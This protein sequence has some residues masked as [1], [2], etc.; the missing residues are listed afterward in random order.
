MDTHAINTTDLVIMAVCLTFSYPNVKCVKTVS[1]TQTVPA[2]VAIAK[3]DKR[4]IRKV[5]IVLTVAVQT[6]KSL[7]AKNAKMDFTTVIVAPNVENV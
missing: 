5:E 1:T 7:C 4:V 3:M 6:S 2:Y